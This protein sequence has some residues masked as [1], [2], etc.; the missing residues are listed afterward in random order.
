MTRPAESQ[1]L[2]DPTGRFYRVPPEIL[3]RNGRDPDDVVWLPAYSTIM[4]IYQAPYLRV[5]YG[6]KGLQEAERI[7]DETAEWGHDAHKLIAFISMGGKITTWDGIAEPVRNA[8]RAWVRWSISSGFK[9]QRTELPVYSMKYWYAGTL[10]AQGLFYK[11]QGIA[12]YKTGTGEWF[13]R[14][15][16]LQLAAYWTAYHETY[17]DAPR[18]K[19]A[20]SVILSRETGNPVEYTRTP[21]EVRHDFTYFLAALKLWKYIKRDADVDARERALAEK[22]GIDAEEAPRQEAASGQASHGAVQPLIQA[23][24]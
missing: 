4:D 10:D 7:R 12:D 3:I 14:T 17:P 16:W 2:H 21:R 13:Y 24:A 20:R 9:A 18:L 22:G 8:L 19:I 5:W 1:H 23:T 15:Y 6:K 11:L